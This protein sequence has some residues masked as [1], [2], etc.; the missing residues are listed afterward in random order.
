MARYS[1]FNA[2]QIQDVEEL[3]KRL[4]RWSN[5]LA[6]ELESRDVQLDNRPTRGVIALTTV[7]DY[8]TPQ[9][10]AIV[11]ST[12]AHTYYGWDAVT[13]VWDALS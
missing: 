8:G 1:E 5:S 9:T 4:E 11:Y 6:R 3:V 10:G 12:S 7:T 2:Y 13:S